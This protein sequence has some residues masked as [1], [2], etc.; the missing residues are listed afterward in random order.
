[1]IAVTHSG[2]FRMPTCGSM[3]VSLEGTLDMELGGR[4][5][6]VGVTGDYREAAG[7]EILLF[8]PEKHDLG[9]GAVAQLS[10]LSL[11]G[12]CAELGG[13]VELKVS[14]TQHSGGSL[15]DG[16]EDSLSRVRY[17]AELHFAT[18]LELH[19]P[20]AALHATSGLSLG[21]WLLDLGASGSELR[22]EEGKGQL[23]T[24][25]GEVRGRLTGVSL[26]MGHAEIADPTPA[27]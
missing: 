12:D 15:G 27:N 3:R 6:H 25:G 21:G 5:V 22:M 14:S 23:A 11:V 10:R 1:M 9:P 8:G 18:H 16:D 19:T 20:S 26:V 4:T 7:A 17:P 13:R 2:A 24:A